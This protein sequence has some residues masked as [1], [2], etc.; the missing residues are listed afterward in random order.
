MSFLEQFNTG[1]FEKVQQAIKD[2]KAFG[3]AV[4][5][6]IKMPELPGTN[7]VTKRRSVALQRLRGGRQ[8]TILSQTDRLGG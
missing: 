6:P 5:T 7:K 2:N 1:G 8:S 4:P 3:K